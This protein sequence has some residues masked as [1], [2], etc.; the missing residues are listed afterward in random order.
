MSVMPIILISILSSIA[1]L[2]AI[3]DKFLGNEGERKIIINNEKVIPVN[4]DN[5]LLNFLSDNKIFIPSACGGKA[6]CGHCKVKVTSG[7]GNTLPTEDIFLNKKEKEDGVRLACQVKVKEDIEIEL[8]SDLLS[9][10]EYKTKLVELTDLT[11]DIKLLRLQLISPETIDFLP[12][13]YAQIKVPGIEVFRAYS[14]ASKPSDRNILEFIIRLVPGGTATTYVHKALEVGDSV[15]VTGPYGH[16]YLRE[17]SDREIVCIAGGS[18]KAPIRSI[19]YHLMEQGM[20]R[21]ITYFFGARTK[22]D[23][24]YTEELMEI[25]KK[26]PNFTY[27]P[28][29]SDPQPEDNWTGE[30]GLITNVVDSHYETLE[31]A[32][33]YL[34]GSPGMIDACD[35]VLAKNGMKKENILYDKF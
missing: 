26:F 24:Y 23:L 4:S 7:G 30:T 22:K 31:H 3:A 9:V 18:G 1:I 11:H 28:A 6:T 12:G 21:K 27:V 29:L 32:E 17:D 10:Q 8:P 19:I 35:V 13:Q 34:C 14:I 16:F 33:A 15:T 20:H 25:S 2:L 5:T